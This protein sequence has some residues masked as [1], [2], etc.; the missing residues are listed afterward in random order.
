MQSITVPS[1]LPPRPHILPTALV[2]WPSLH[3]SCQT[4]WLQVIYKSLL[5]KALPYLS[6]PVTIAAL[7]RS[8]RSS[9]SSTR[10][11]RFLCTPISLLA[12]SFSVCLPFQC[13][14]AILLLLRHHGLFIASTPLSYLICTHRILYIDFLFSFFLLYYWLYVLFIPSV[15]LCCCVYQTALLYLDQ[16][17]VENENL[18]STGLPD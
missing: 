13:L 2:G 18:F 9:R 11:S 17:P 12:H 6:S 8:T 5:G 1:V 4:D 10:S 3:T 15:T 14:I 16:V 7:T